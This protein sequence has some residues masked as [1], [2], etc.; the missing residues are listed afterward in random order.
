MALVPI[1]TLRM[2]G[3]HVFYSW[4]KVIVFVNVNHNVI[5]VNGIEIMM[6]RILITLIRTLSQRNFPNFACQ[7]VYGMFF[8]FKL[9]FLFNNLSLRLYFNSFSYRRHIAD[10]FLT[11]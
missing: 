5:I 6:S 9:S 2:M 7:L 11:F 8:T 1:F 10:T 4:F 3:F